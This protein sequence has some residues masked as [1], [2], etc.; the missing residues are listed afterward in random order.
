MNWGMKLMI[1]MGAFMAFIITLGTLM[2]MRYDD[3][4]LVDQNYYEKGQNYNLELEKKQN[5]LHDRMLPGIS[6]P[7]GELIINFPAQVRYRLICRRPSD[8]RMDQSLTGSTGADGIVAIQRKSL[9]PGPWSIRIE[10]E[11]G[12]RKYLFEDEIVIP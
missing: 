5:A 9:K 11:A 1:G 6:T 8:A 3:D 7:D 2:M 10:Y 4:S 12:G